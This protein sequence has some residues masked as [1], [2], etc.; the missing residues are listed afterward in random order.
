MIRKMLV[1]GAAAV[2]PVTG[3]AGAALVAT[4]GVAGAGA[5][6]VQAIH[7]NVSGTIAFGGGGI[8]STGNVN[9]D[10]KTTS[11]VTLN[12]AT[13]SD[14]GCSGSATVSNITQSA[15]KCKSV[16]TLGPVT[17][18]GLTVYP[19]Q[20]YLPNCDAA[21]KLKENNS[22]WGFLGGVAVGGVTNS[23]TDGIA[24][25]LSKGVPYTDNGVALT[26][27]VNQTPGAGVTQ[28]L[29]G[30]VCGSGAGF[31]VNGT[32]KKATTHTWTLDLCLSGDS[33]ANTTNNFLS[34]LTA[35][36]LSTAGA[37]TPFADGINVATATVNPSGSSLT[38]N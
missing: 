9:S 7:C 6:A 10:S 22:A 32:V 11:V 25:A 33:G 13:G 35:E 30:G 21:S 27:L 1:A 26:L 15:T 37:T 34:D 18:L 3:L 2:L 5:P 36:V 8:K 16:V 29:P 31:Q 20:T 4:S 17:L 14:A 19:S 28:I 12:S 38:I 23:T 24:T